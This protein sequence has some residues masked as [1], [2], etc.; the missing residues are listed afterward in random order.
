MCLHPEGLSPFI[1]VL[2]AIKMPVVPVEHRKC[3]LNFQHA[4]SY[5]YGCRKMMIVE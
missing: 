1:N 5:Q 2:G 4:G 3:P